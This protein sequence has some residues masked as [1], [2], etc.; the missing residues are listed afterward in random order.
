VPPPPLPPQF[1]GKLTG[2]P[3]TST[4][5]A[6]G[7]A[8]ASRSQPALAQVLCLCMFLCR[9]ACNKQ[10]VHYCQYAVKFRAV[11]RSGLLPSSLP[12]SHVLSVLGA[13]H[14]HPVSERAPE[15]QIGQRSTAAAAPKPSQV[16]ET[17]VIM[18]LLLLLALAGS[19][20]AQ[21]RPPA[22]F[23]PATCEQRCANPNSFHTALPAV[24]D[25]TQGNRVFQWSE[26]LLTVVSPA[27]RCCM[28]H[29]CRQPAP[30][31]PP[32]AS[33]LQIAQLVQVGQMSPAR[34]ARTIGVASAAMFDAV[35]LF[36]DGWA[37]VSGASTPLPPGVGASPANVGAAVS[38][39]AYTFITR[40][41]PQVG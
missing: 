22:Q 26:V 17:M 41:F 30:H 36:T 29:A 1:R 12:T 32:P 4:L 23:F 24:P 15:V 9:S 25:P 18:L 11:C 19:S 40:S 27:Q 35:A 31:N 21:G 16:P 5:L 3:S 7:D 39:A 6:P 34:A 28:T 38:G 37:P 2:P 8:L 13:V 10:G 14:L 33:R 20:N